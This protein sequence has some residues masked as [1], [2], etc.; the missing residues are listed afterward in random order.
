MVCAML[1]IA[2]IE[3]EKRYTNTERVK[4]EREKG[5]I[6]RQKESALWRR[7]GKGVVIVDEG[8]SM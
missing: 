1:E 7:I 6:V 5:D 4:T 2:Y 8:S 3:G